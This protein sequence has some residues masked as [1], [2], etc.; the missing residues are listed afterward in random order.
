MEGCNRCHLVTI[1]C[2]LVEFGCAHCT[3]LA[4]LREKEGRSGKE[5]SGK[6][7]TLTINTV[8]GIATVWQNCVSH[9]QGRAL[10]KRE[11]TG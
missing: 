9:W 8:G 4:L 3:Q 5:G 2:R 6:T 7:K 1:G 10:E 11:N